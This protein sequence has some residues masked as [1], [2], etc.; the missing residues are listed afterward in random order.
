[1]FIGDFYKNVKSMLEPEFTW[2]LLRD[3]GKREDVKV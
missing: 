1:M 3:V 2:I